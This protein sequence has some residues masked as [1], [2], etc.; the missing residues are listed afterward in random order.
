MGT[1]GGGGTWA[2]PRKGSQGGALGFLRSGS[3]RFPQGWLLESTC[4][5]QAPLWL[6]RPRRPSLQSRGSGWAGPPHP[7]P[8]SWPP[9]WSEAARPTSG[10]LIRD[11]HSA[12]HDWS[13]WGTCPAVLYWPVVIGSRGHV[14]CGP[15]F[16]S[17]DWL[18][19]GTWPAQRSLR[20]ARASAQGR[21]AGTRGQATGLL[22]PLAPLG[23]WGTGA[24]PR[25]GGWGGTG[26]LGWRRFRRR[27]CPG[28]A[29][30]RRPTRWRARPLDARPAPVT[31][32]LSVFRPI[33]TRSLAAAPG[34]TWGPPGR[35]QAPQPRAPLWSAEQ[36]SASGRQN[37][38]LPP[39]AG[40]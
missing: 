36:F 22:G 26:V 19:G 29:G 10:G 5:S 21:S 38:R 18:T 37:G 6:G 14:P 13:P 35:A 23:S 17:C 27:P 12:V 8:A 3:P 39:E 25:D 32:L 34:A 4:S 20:S 2:S 7:W 40:N 33:S 31:F 16:A 28:R 11:S 9:D 30:W 15:F 24:G 1:G